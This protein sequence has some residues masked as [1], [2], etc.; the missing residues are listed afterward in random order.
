MNNAGTSASFHQQFQSMENVVKER[1]RSRNDIPHKK[2]KLG[3]LTE[4]SYSDRSINLN[5]QLHKIVIYYEEPTAA[6]L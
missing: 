5:R 2:N 4:E 3:V 1:T 6:A